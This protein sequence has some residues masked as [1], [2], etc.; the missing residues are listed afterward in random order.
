MMF[1]GSHIS[2]PRRPVLVLR[3]AHSAANSPKNEQIAV[4]VASGSAFVLEFSKV[5]LKG[6]RQ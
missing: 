3:L 1:V 6:T 2:I 5:L 4:K